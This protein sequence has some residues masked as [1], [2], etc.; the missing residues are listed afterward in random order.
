MKPSLQL[1]LITVEDVL[2][3][4][5]DRS[6]VIVDCR[7]NLS[8]P[9]ASEWHYRAEHVPGAHYLDMARDLSSPLSA[10]GGRH[11]LP[12]R[13]AFE[14][15]MRALGIGR[16][17][18]VVAYDDGDGSGAARLWWLLRYFG[19]RQVWVMQGGWPAWM[20]RG[21]GASSGLSVPSSTGD[22]LAAPNSA[23]IVDYQAISENPLDFVLVDSRSP[24][25]YRGEVEPIDVKAGHIPGALSWDYRL[26]QTAPGHYH[27]PAWLLDY[28]KPLESQA[29]RLVIYCGSGVTAC[30]NLLALSLAGIDARLY[31]GSWSDWIS[32]PEAPLAYGDEVSG[33]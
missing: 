12:D 5:S 23:M 25:R 13:A 32:Y 8:A 6:T 17:S 14:D 29:D 9:Q 26:T 19:H 7:Y 18:K 21:F 1:P 10:H 31:P 28:H 15:R 22:F 16:A 24:E 11:P 2:D 30:V 20:K 4:L 27:H 3:M 33:W